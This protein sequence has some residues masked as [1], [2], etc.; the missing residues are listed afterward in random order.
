LGKL[1]DDRPLR[2]RMGAAARKHMEKFDWNVVSRQW[3]SAYLEI[4]AAP[5][6]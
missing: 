6:T 4:A 3:Q 2:E 1:I 5:A